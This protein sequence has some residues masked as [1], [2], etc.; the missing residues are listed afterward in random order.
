MQTTKLIKNQKKNCSLDFHLNKKNKIII[1]TQFCTDFLYFSGFP[2]S[3]ETKNHIN[4]QAPTKF[5]SNYFYKNKKKKIQL[6]LKCPSHNLIYGK[7]AC[8]D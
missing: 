7:Q 6:N 3:M 2:T 8:E 5:L 4:T 1:I